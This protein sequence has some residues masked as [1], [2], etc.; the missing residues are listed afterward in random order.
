MSDLRVCS[1]CGW[2]D[3]W[4]HKDYCDPKRGAVADALIAAVGLP[5]TKLG[6]G[7]FMVTFYLDGKPRGSYIPSHV[8]LRVHANGR[9]ELDKLWTLTRFDA[10]DMAA[11]VA[12]LK[13][14]PLGGSK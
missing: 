14:S 1:K 6:Y 7:D 4:A 10:K 5:A 2:Y 11:V 3:S 13:A 8:T 12:A 9:F